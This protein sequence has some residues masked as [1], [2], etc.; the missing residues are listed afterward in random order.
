M[1]VGMC[2]IAAFASAFNKFKGVSEISYELLVSGNFR[3][4]RTGVSCYQFRFSGAVIRVTLAY[5][6]VLVG[7]IESSIRRPCLGK[8]GAC[9]S[10]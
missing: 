7:P 10:L 3:D 4:R 9:H 5:L 1:K 6:L 2:K 8:F